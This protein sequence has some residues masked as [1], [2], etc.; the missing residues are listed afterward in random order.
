MRKGGHL[1]TRRESD[2]SLVE[3]SCLGSE[4][5]PEQRSLMLGNGV[6]D[7]GTVRVNERRFLTIVLGQASAA[8]R[9]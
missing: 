2:E 5:L 8:V 7:S 1:V 4:W 9:P 6:T 3:Y